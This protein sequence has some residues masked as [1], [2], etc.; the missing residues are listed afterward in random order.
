MMDRLRTMCWTKPARQAIMVSTLTP[1]RRRRAKKHQGRYFIGMR[2]GKKQNLVSSS[3]F[4]AA[5]CH[6]KMN[7]N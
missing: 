2:Q 5:F 3:G 7:I 4:M 6:R 1:K